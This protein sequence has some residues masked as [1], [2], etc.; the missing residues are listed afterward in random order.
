MSATRVSSRK[1]DALS[2]TLTGDPT[3]PI[4][5][6]KKLFLSSAD[7]RQELRE[8]VRVRFLGARERLEPVGDLGKAFFAGGLR[9]PGIHLG[10]LVGLALDRALEIQ[11]G[12]SER[13]ARGRV[14]RGLQ[15]IHVPVRVAGLSLGRVAEVAGDL[16]VA[17]DV[18]LVGEIK[19][20]AVRLA[21]ARERMFEVLVCLGSLEFCHGSSFDEQQLT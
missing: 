1:R 3:A 9:E 15:V 18:G 4:V 16:R 20:P 2:T 6:S 14:A 10:V 7:R 13:K 19:V 5:F 12:R 11:R 17:L 8:A 21:L